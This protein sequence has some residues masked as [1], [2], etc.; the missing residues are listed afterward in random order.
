[1][2]D[3]IRYVIIHE[4]IYYQVKWMSYTCAR[5]VQNHLCKIYCLLVC[6]LRD[7]CFSHVSW[8][9]ILVTCNFSKSKA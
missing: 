1:M 5:L 3:T 9:S 4:Y 6:S 7:V 8:S 2:L